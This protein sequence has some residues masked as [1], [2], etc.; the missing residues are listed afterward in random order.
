MSD[1]FAAKERHREE[2]EHHGE[3]R[4]DRTRE[5]LHYG[6]IDQRVVVQFA[7]NRGVLA[8]SVE[9]HDAVV[10]G[11]AN[12]R[13]ERGQ[14]ERI[15]FPAEEMSQNGFHADRDEN[16][17]QHGDNRRNAVADRVLHAAKR[18]GDVGENKDCRQRHRAR[19]AFRDL[20][21]D[22]GADLRKVQHRHR[23]AEAFLHRRDQFSFRLVI[24][25]FGANREGILAK[26]L[27]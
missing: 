12:H 17:V 1:A 27:H 8:D 7:V 4:V 18:V 26:R 16:I 3:L 5:S 13:Q 23:A 6:M 20:F 11:E 9:D 10:D 2:G 25:H 21:P 22:S 15:R 19:G 14:K 24:H